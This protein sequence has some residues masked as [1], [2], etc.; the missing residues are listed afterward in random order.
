MAVKFSIPDR[1]EAAQM[2]ALFSVLIHSW[3]TTNFAEAAR[4]KNELEQYGVT[5]RF[6]SSRTR[7]GAAS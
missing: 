2:I 7:S 6:P 3:R 4:A 1:D 5:I